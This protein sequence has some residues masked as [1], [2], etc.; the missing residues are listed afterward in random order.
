MSHPRSQHVRAGELDRTVT[1]QRSTVSDDGFRQELTWAAHGGPVRAR[2]TD[3]SDGERWR[4]AE[5][6][7]VITTRFVV[8]YNRF[9]IDLTPKDRL[10]CEGQE[11]DITGIKEVGGR[12]R[13]LEIT[14][15]A[16]ADK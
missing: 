1:F 15:A 12:R 6:S 8:R 13:W 14:A 7:A 10:L 5:V 11:Y 3:L 4:A 9:T 2:K 16:R